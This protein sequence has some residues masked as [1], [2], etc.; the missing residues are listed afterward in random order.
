MK[1]CKFFARRGNYDISSQDHLC[2]SKKEQLP[3]VQRQPNARES[4]AAAERSYIMNNMTRGK[5]FSI[6]TIT[7]SLSSLIS[8][9]VGVVLARLLSQTNLGIY[10]EVSFVFSFVTPFMLLEL[11]TATL[12][13]LPRFKG[14]ERWLYIKSTYI[15]SIV[16]GI[17]FI[18]LFF[19]LSPLLEAKGTKVQGTANLFILISIAA[20]FTFLVSFFRQI[21][22]TIRELKILFSFGIVYALCSFLPIAAYFLASNE[23]QKLEFIILAVVTQSVIG[24]AIAVSYF[25]RSKAKQKDSFKLS[26]RK[27]FCFIQQNWREQLR[28]SIYFVA[29][30]PMALLSKDFAKLIIMGYLSANSF[31]V[32]TI[33]A[34][35][36]PFLPTLRTALVNTLVPEIADKYHETGGISKETLHVWRRA[37]QLTALIIIPAFVFLEIFSYEFI[38]GLYTTKYIDSV[39]IFQAFLFL[40]PS[41]LLTFDIFLQ[42]TG[43]TK[44]IFVS[45]I[46]FLIVNVILS[47]FLLKFLGLVGPA[48]GTVIANFVSAAYLWSESRKVIG[49]AP[50]GAAVRKHFLQIFVESLIA[51]IVTKSILFITCANLSYLMQFFIGL[52][53][54][55]CIVLIIWYFSYRET[56]RDFW[57]LARAMLKR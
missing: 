3:T 39:P 44:P 43:N 29:R 33:G 37:I 52:A 51:A 35:V 11:P 31:A 19:F 13:F 28:Y 6:F 5:T 45:S 27:L 55:S 50:F 40:I 8:L 48:I 7:D 21:L 15:F 32:Y 41:Y 14:E 36:I 9:F 56:L 20:P 42:G 18:L 23:G 47:L 24:A 17:A 25:L 4:N 53:A 57:K 1:S 30:L 10:R 49:E 16:V 22:I 26:L 46:I 12:Y 38:V 2:Q 34:V 54:S